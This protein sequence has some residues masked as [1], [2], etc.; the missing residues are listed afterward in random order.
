[1]SATSAITFKD[2]YKADHRS[3]YPTQTAY[4]LTNFT[5]RKSRVEGVDSVVCFGINYFVKEFLIEY[6][7]E[8]FFKKTKE[9]IMG[10]Y[11]RRMEAY[12][13]KG[14]LKYEHV[15]ALHDLGYLPVKL[16]AL[17]EGSLVKCGVP[18]LTLENTLPEFFWLPNFL[19]TILSC[20]IWPMATSATFAFNFRLIFDEY[21]LKTTGST[22]FSS[23]F[24]G[25]DFSA[26]GMFGR[27]A[28]AMSGA[29]HLTCFAGT[30]TIWAI[31]FL[32]DWYNADVEKEL[33]GASVPAT[34]HSVMCMGMKDDELETFR[35][36]IE[37]VYPDGIV[38][39]V[40]DTWDLWKV[41]TEYM[42]ALKLKIMERDGKVVLRPDSGDPVKI[43]TGYTALEI[44]S[45]NGVWYRFED[46]KIVGHGMTAPKPGAK[47]LSE[48]EIKGVIEVL[49]EQFGGTVSDQG[50][51][52][53]DEHIGTI[54][55]D[56]ISLARARA[57]CK[58]LMDK[59]FASTNWVA[60]IGSYTYQYV[61]RDTFGW[62]MKAT[63]GELNKDGTVEEREIF[64]DPITDDGTK[65]SAKGRLV[66][67][68]DDK[69]EFFLE[70]QVT[71][72]EA[73][74]GEL[75][76]VFED[77]KLLVDAKLSDI[78]ELINNN[79]KRKLT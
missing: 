70:D 45:Y 24:Q 52:I 31:D 79:I 60:G 36:L 73:E 69:G 17:P 78:R 62:A 16:K 20:Q 48:P 4:I 71:K 64:K 46:L 8:T 11:K 50:Y 9:E 14:K 33:V 39:I 30:D 55:G 34:E 38:S 77:G 66:V 15:E 72:Q 42:P 35:R 19:E 75:I 23:T 6:F 25:H 61:T 27:M 41:L 40:S 44:D 1:M 67:Y 63:Y 37:D 3:Q 54:Y 58:R 29:A 53:L 22:A 32:E 56:G 7:N 47:P 68:K 51:K 28:A 43:L 59:G 26:R 5:P 57:I 65:K 49:Y 13:G 21:A 74:G 10:R 76:T 2:G 18:I 12:L